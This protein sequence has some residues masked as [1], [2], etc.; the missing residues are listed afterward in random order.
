MSFGIYFDTPNNSDGNPEWSAAYGAGA[1]TLGTQSITEINANEWYR[2]VIPCGGGKNA[3]LGN[4][5][6]LLYS[7][8][9]LCRKDM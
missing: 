7:P 8:L 2:F 9:L 5:I 3:I 1:L 6:P 4:Q